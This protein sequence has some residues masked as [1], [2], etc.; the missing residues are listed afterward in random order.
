MFS[1]VEDC[2]QLDAFELYATIREYILVR[3]IM[4]QLAERLPED[5][6]Y[7]LQFLSNDLEAE[8]MYRSNKTLFESISLEIA[9]RQLEKEEK[10]AKAEA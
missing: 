8:I 6:K 9:L 10:K 3:I 5:V 1:G 4:H 7:A 2:S